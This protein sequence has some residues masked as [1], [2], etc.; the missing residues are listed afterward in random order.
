MSRAMRPLLL[1][2]P[3][4]IVGC[5]QASVPWRPPASLVSLN[6]PGRYFI[7]ASAARAAFTIDIAEDAAVDRKASAPRDF[8]ILRI[9]SADDRIV[10]E[11][12]FESSYGIFRLDLVDLTGDGVEEFVLITGDGQ[13]TDVRAEAVEVNQRIGSDW[14][15]LARHAM[16][17]YYGYGLRWWYTPHYVDLNADGALDL[18]LVRGCDEPSP[19][20]ALS[21]FDPKS[22]P[23]AARLDFVWD[24]R[25][26]RMVL[27][28]EERSAAALPSQ[29]RGMEGVAPPRPTGPTLEAGR[30]EKTRT[31]RV[32]AGD[33]LWTIAERE[34]GDGRRWEEILRANQ[35]LRDPTQMTVDREIHLPKR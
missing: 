25:A 15:V 4:M 1:V 11:R 28:A 17:A 35:D 9:R 30:S 33:T 5:S 2:I 34:L 20:E 6:E 16:S 13:G 7:P 29:R 8:L 31:Y 22:I 3:V 12:K 24:A 23:D 18:R 27:A 14:K 10:A 21:Y 32:Q 19:H 26:A